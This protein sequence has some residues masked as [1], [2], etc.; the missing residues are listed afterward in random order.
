MGVA[1]DHER[2]GHSCGDALA[3]HFDHRQVGRVVAQLDAPAYQ[4]RVDRVLV[5]LQRH[6]GGLGDP[7]GAHPQERLPQPVGA[8]GAR[9]V[10]GL[11]ALGRG[12]AR[13]GVGTPVGDLFGPRLE[14]VVELGQALDAGVL[15]FGHEPLP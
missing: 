11:E 10:A 6:G 15:G 5:G 4:C 12:L 1:A 3:E 2:C 13:L 14:A 9:R 7:P 8:R